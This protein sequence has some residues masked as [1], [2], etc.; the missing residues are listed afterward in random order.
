MGRQIRRLSFVGENFVDNYSAVYSFVSII[1]VSAFCLLASKSIMPLPISSSVIC[2][3]MCP[4]ALG[5]EHDVFISRSL[6]TYN[7]LECARS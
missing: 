1:N 2:T 5:S 4:L 3:N 6:P 7:Q